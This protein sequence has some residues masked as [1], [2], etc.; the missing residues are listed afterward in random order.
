MS[1]ISEEKNNNYMLNY[2]I[3]QHNQTSQD[4]SSTSSWTDLSGSEI[5]YTPS[6]GSDFVIYE[7]VFAR[8]KLT[9]NTINIKCKLL[10]S[11]D[12]GS[13]WSDYGNNTNTMFG[14]IHDQARSR[15]VTAIKLCLNSWGNTSKKLKISALV[16]SG[17]IQLHELSRFYD[18]NGQVSDTRYIKPYVTCYSV[19]N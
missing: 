14:S 1:H 16:H 4:L 11:D 9:S 19:R 15:K 8:A 2:K 3:V 17:N 18:E 7:Y 6:V 10:Y 13:T 5:S 12:N